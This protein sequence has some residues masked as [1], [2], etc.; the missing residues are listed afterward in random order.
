VELT[1]QEELALQIILLTEMPLFQD[2]IP[3]YRP[4]N[5]LRAEWTTFRKGLN[6]LLRPTELGR[7]EYTQGDNIM[8]I[9]SGVPTGRWGTTK[10]FSANATGQIRGF[11]TFANTYTGTSEIIALTDQGFLAKKSGTTSTIITGQSYPSGSVVRSEQL[12]G[13]TYFVSKDRPLTQYRGISLQV[14]AT[15]SPPTGLTATNISGVTGTNIQSWRIT[16]L[17]PT[18]GETNASGAIVLSNLPQDLTKTLVRVNWTGTS[19]ATISGY[20]IYRGTQGNERFLA[21]VGPSITRFDD[22]GEPA[23]EVAL[24][25]LSNSTGGIKSEFITKVA[26]RL[27]MVDATDKNKLLISGRY[28][29]QYSFNW[30]DGGGSIYIDPDSGQDITGIT[31]QP[32][33]NKIV[34]YKDYAHYAVE[35]S[36]V[37]FGSYNLLDASYIPIST[38]TGC[39]SPDTIQTVE[40]DIF[41][42][43]RKGLY[44]T[45]YEPNFLNIIRTNEVSARIRPYLDLLNDNDYKNA[46]ALYVDNK[47]LLSF[48]NRKEIVV[49][50]RE[51]GAFAG[52]WKLPWGISKMIRYIDGS[53]TERWVIGTTDS[54][55]IY[56]FETSVNSDDGVTI[57]KTIKTNKEQFNTWTELKI[58]EIFNVLLRNITGSVT[59]NILLEDRNGATSTVKT[60]TIVGT[61]VSGKMGW[62]ASK[63]GQYVW[64]KWNG[65]PVTGSDEFPRWGTLYKEGRLIQIEVTST[66]SNSNFELLGL[67]FTAT[68]Q[69]RGSLSSSQRV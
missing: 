30:V 33:S 11:G 55:Q 27:L 43:G 19:A 38:G 20:Q 42:F 9:G 10:Y 65:T 47:Y 25:P 24:I 8:L 53:G 54:N 62:G 32:G 2:R 29:Y 57:T 51:R 46:C 34:V 64:G 60:F 14:F 1:Q 67:D 3:P 56:T 52:I 5:P 40:N 61:A 45:G 44:V 7:D 17:S 59:V 69:G 15:L 49:Y 66:Q 31:T 23:S 50:D 37:S 6:L 28:P 58:I 21:A 41:Y 48:P 4:R 13:I 36:T 26:D 12:G 63:W 68:S 18:G 16:T 22:I 39:S 35:L